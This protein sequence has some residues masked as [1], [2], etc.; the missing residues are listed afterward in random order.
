MKMT[1]TL[2]LMVK[3]ICGVLYQAGKKHMVIDINDLNQ[4]FFC[5]G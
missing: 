2:I 5:N 3:R 1:G 4:E